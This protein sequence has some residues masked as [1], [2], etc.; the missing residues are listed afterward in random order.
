MSEIWL[1]ALNRLDKRVSDLEARFQ[2]PDKKECQ[3]DMNCERCHK[4]QPKPKKCGPGAVR[5]GIYECAC[6]KPSEAVEELRQDE[7]C[8]AREPVWLWCEKHQKAE[9]GQTMHKIREIQSLLR[10]QEMWL[11]QEL[12][13]LCRLARDRR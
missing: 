7:C 6:I 9:Q 8:D 11:N 4:Q 12:R 13:Q 3:C 10:N 5:N 2:E 1:E